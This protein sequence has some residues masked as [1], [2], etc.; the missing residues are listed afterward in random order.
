MPKETPQKP[1]E[2]PQ[3]DQTTVPK[4]AQLAVSIPTT[5]LPPTAAATNG[6]S[7]STHAQQ[8][9]RHRNEEVENL[10]GGKWRQRRVATVNENE[11][12]EKSEMTSTKLPLT[13]G[14]ILGRGPR[15]LTRADVVSLRLGRNGSVDVRGSMTRLRGTFWATV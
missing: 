13:D 3:F 2:T 11:L 1:K 9:L 14:D 7:W 5:L 10:D 15:C 6:S 4:E 12:H 8:E